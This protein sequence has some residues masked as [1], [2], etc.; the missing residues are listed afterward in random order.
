MHHLV[1]HADK[2][3]V[4]G[5]AVWLEKKRSVDALEPER[6]ALQDFFKL[7]QASASCTIDYVVHAIKLEVLHCV[8]VAGE[9]Q[10]HP[11]LVVGET[12][13]FL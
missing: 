12:E 5:V 8:V 10:V 13:L 2:S 11:P 6:R 7:V 1:I 9:H 3:T 4:Q